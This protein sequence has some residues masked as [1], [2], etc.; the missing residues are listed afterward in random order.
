LQLAGTSE[1]GPQFIGGWSFYKGAWNAICSRSINMDLLIALGTSV[2]YFYSVALLVL[3]DV[4][5]VKVEERDV[6]CEVSAV[7]IAFVLLGKYME[8]MFKKRSSPR[9]ASCSTSSPPPPA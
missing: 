2:A 9:C 6:Y 1:R 3:P 8:E 7:I 4:L 5:P